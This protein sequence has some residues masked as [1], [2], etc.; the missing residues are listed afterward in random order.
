MDHLLVDGRD[1]ADLPSLLEALSQLH[2][3]NYLLIPLIIWLRTLGITIT[4]SGVTGSLL[5]EE[6]EWCESPL[7]LSCQ[8]VLS[9]L[10]ALASCSP[11]EQIQLALV[12]SVL[13]ALDIKYIY[14]TPLAVGTDLRTLRLQEGQ[15]VTFSEKATSASFAA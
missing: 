13:D 12:L 6:I 15:T 4:D 10:T 11:E 1:G 3:N 5:K 8:Q 7:K 9:E 2:N 14:L